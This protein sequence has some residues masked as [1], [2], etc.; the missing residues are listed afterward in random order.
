[1]KQLELPNIDME[2]AMIFCNLEHNEL[3][4]AIK[5]IELEVG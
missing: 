3:E 1:L 4:D 2:E 5:N